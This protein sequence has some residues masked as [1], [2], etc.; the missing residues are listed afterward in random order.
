MHFRPRIRYGMQGKRAALRSATIMIRQPLQRMTGMQ[1]SDIDIYRKITREKT[2]NMVSCTLANMS[3]GAR[4]V[5]VAH[6]FK[7]YVHCL[8]TVASRPDIHPN[9][10]LPAAWQGMQGFAAARAA[11]LPYTPQP[12]TVVEGSYMLRVAVSNR[13]PN[14]WLSTHRRRRR[15]SSG[16]SSGLATSHPMRRHPMGS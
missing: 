2:H 4:S 8:C 14:T 5:R 15:T 11:S 9:V 10:S 12:D 13:R 7:S 6:V 1:A 3:H 16:T